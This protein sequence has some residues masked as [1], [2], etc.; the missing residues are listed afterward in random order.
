MSVWHPFTQLRG[1]EPLGEVVAAEGAWLHLADGR[2]LLDG[3]SSWWV[4]LHG[5][6]RPEI[7]AAVAAQAARL[8][9]VILADFVHPAAASLT[10]ALQG[11][12]PGGPKRVFFSDDGSTAVEVA[13]KMAWQHQREKA[14][15]RHRLVAF[16]GG[17]HGDTLGAMSV[18]ARDVFTLCFEGMLLPVT[19][20][21]YDDVD[22]LETFFA[23]HGD[24]VVAAIVE[25]MVQCAGGMRVASPRFLQALDAAVHRAGALW[26]ADE[27]AVGF[28]RTGR[29]WGCDHA[30]V[31]PDLVALSK[32]LTGGTLPMGIT[33]A[34]EAIYES[35]LGA[36]KRS[37]FLHGHSYTGNPIAAAAALASL[38]LVR[39]EDTPAKFAAFEGIYRGWFDRVRSRAALANPRA[40][41]GI[42]AFDVADGGGYHDPIGRRVQAAALRRGLYVR[43]LGSVVYLMPPAAVTLAELDAACEGLLASVDEALE[44]R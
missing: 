2:R 33:A 11:V 30:S 28:G 31:S 35:F 39:Q 19:F 16:E 17:Y 18:G 34:S 7:A 13:L 6:A 4:T 23:A 15:G 21:P 12:L 38:H 25:P 1:F 14:S 42:F 44:A 5:H 22:A 43:P 32:G 40:L 37:A 10:A 20:L 41:G 8:D 36:D 9:Q 27:V 3:I 29:M 26:I 24:A